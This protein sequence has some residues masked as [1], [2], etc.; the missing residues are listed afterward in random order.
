M[1]CY[2]RTA[3]LGGYSRMYFLTGNILEEN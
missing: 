2:V 3:N 1:Y